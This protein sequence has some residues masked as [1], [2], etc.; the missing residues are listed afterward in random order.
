MKARLI[1]PIGTRTY[2][3]RYVGASDGS[4]IC[5]LPEWDYHNAEAVGGESSEPAET[6]WQDDPR[7]LAM[8]SHDDARW[9]SRCACGYVF[10]EDDSWQLTYKRWWNTDSGYPE[11]G[12]LFW[13]PDGGL[14]RDRQKG[15]E[16]PHLYAICPDGRAW[17]ID[18]GSSNGNG[19]TRTGEPPTI[20][21]SPSIWTNMPHGYHGFLQNGEWTADLSGQTFDA[22]PY[23]FA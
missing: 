19:W 18:G 12:D 22:K 7:R 8:P 13:R 4:K 1:Q 17:D 14:S 20:T 23:I 2:L 3:C 11:P 6:F 21:C 10:T 5:P 16:T 15:D 9:P